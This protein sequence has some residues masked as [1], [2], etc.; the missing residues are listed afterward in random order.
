MTTRKTEEQLRKAAIVKVA[1]AALTVRYRV[2][3]DEELNRVLPDLEDEFDRRIQAG[4]LPGK[5]NLKALVEE[6]LRGTE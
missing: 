1:R 4:E 3:L 5:V 2:M 6:G